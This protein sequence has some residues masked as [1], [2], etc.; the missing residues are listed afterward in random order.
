QA[1]VRGAAPVIAEVADAA[2]GRS[3][4]ELGGF[5]PVLDLASCHHERADARLFAS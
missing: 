2:V 3:L 1:L 5:A 4:E